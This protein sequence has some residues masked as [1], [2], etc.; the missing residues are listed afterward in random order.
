[1]YLHVVEKKGLEFLSRYINVAVVGGEWVVKIYT[2]GFTIA[3]SVLQLQLYD[4][5]E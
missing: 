3:G 4:P 5:S 2:R 1:M